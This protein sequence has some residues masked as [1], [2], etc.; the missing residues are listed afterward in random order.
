MRSSDVVATGSR[1]GGA[2]VVDS[3]RDAAVAVLGD[4]F[5]ANGMTFTDELVSGQRT[6]SVEQYQAFLRTDEATQ[7]T[8]EQHAQ[9]LDRTLDGGASD[10]G[11]RIDEN[12]GD[13]VETKADVALEVLPRG[14]DTDEE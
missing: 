12:M 14:E 7:L 13:M 8:K 11:T 9:I 10:L 4:D 6:L 2:E 3:S 1:K 5:A